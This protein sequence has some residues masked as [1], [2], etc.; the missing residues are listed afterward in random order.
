M[1]RWVYEIQQD[2]GKVIA[3]M[4]KSNLPKKSLVRVD[5]VKEGSAILTIGL[6]KRLASISEVPRFVQKSFSNGAILQSFR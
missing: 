4:E 1:K 3:I 2:A 6:P 5:D